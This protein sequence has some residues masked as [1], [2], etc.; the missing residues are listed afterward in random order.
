M[1]SGRFDQLIYI[2]M[3]DMES[4]QSILRSILRK[5]PVAKDVDLD[6]LAEKTDKFSGADLTEICQR[7]AKLAIRESI[8]RDIERERQRAEAGED[9]MED[10]EDDDDLVP[11]ITR[12]HFEMAMREARRSVSDSDLMKYGSFAQSLQ[13]QRAALGGGMG[14]ANFRFP[15]NSAAGGGAADGDDDDE[16]D[17]YS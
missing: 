1:I 2:P 13:Q 17:L 3:P 7:A 14:A 6:F 5:S 15:E 9:A 10:V 11:E 16:E 4:R 12:S 8:E